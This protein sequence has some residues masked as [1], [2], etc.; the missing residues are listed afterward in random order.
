DTPFTLFFTLALY[1]YLKGLKRPHCLILCGLATGSAIL[2]RSVL[3]LI[4]PGIILAHQIII[5]KRERYRLRYLLIGFLIAILMPAVWYVSQYRLHGERFI[6]AHYTFISG[7]ISAHQ[8]FD[9]GLFLRGLLRY[10]KFLLQHYMPWLPL[11]VAGLF[12]RVKR[13][14]RARDRLAELTVVWLALVIIPFS[15]VEAKVL[16]YII[17]AFPAFSLLAAIPLAGWLARVR[18]EIYLQAGYLALFILVVLITAFP[19]PL[20]RAA[21]MKRLGRVVDLSTR[22]NQRVTIFI[23]GASYRD[24]LV[25]QFLWYS[26]RFCTEAKDTAV[27]MEGL[28]QGEKRTFIVDKGSYE[29]LIAASGVEVEVLMQTENFV[30]FRTVG[31]VSYDRI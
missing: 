4:P 27:L 13:M 9:A 7:K 30:C 19:R 20:V 14:L 1:L 6:A 26:N 15:L 29:R 5:R 21:E 28:R 23:T 2:T 22:P 25:N 24:Y 8:E 11:M 31:E 18:R 17:P 16:R 3:G 10:P 12:I